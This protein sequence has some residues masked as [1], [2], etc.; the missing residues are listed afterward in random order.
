MWFFVYDAAKEKQ[1]EV[2]PQGHCVHSVN[3][4]FMERRKYFSELTCW[5]RGKDVIH[6]SF[7]ELF[8]V[9]EIRPLYPGLKETAPTPKRRSLRLPSRTHTIQRLKLR[10]KESFFIP[11]CLLFNEFLEK[12]LT[13]PKTYIKLIPCKVV[14]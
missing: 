13:I 8:S 5:N 4:E 9:S 1:D 11:G 12:E 2:L 6:S 7:T 3:C 14:F 10:S